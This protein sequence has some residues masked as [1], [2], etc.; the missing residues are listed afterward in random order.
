MLSV[1]VSPDTQ[2]YRPQRSDPC[3]PMCQPAQPAGDTARRAQRSEP[4]FTNVLRLDF[5]LTEKKNGF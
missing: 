5:T 2:T 4:I 1:C 3:F